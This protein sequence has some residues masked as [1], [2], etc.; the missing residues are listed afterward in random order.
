MID[1][2]KQT[3]RAKGAFHVLNAVTIL[4]GGWVSLSDSSLDTLSSF[5]IFASVIVLP[6]L[7]SVTLYRDELLPGENEVIGIPRTENPTVYWSFIAF[8]GLFG[9]F[10]VFQAFLLKHPT[11]Q[12]MA[13]SSSG[14]CST[15]CCNNLLL[16]KP[17][18]L[19]SLVLLVGIAMTARL[20][21]GKKGK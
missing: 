20:I 17:V 7:S 4:I 21:F 6:I 14:W 11:C 5:A 16:A 2:S 12:E 1:Q 18:I 13:L 15:S 3:I 8:Y 9:F 10:A 19:L